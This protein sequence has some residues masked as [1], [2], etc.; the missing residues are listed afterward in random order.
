M[1]RPYGKREFALTLARRSLS[2]YADDGCPQLAASIAYHVLFSLFPLAI[3]L[4]AGTSVVLNATGSRRTV[5]DTI[6]RNVPLSQSG[7]DQL[8][9]LLLGATGQLSA[10]GFVG[11]LG[12]LY[13][14][15]G[16]M[17]ALRTALSR[18]WDLEEA[19]PYLR[20]KLVDLGLVLLVALL[21][22]A[23]LGLTIALRF[24]GGGGSWTTSLV[25]PLV[26]A[27]A[28]VLF[29][30]RVV[31]DT[32]VPFREAWAPAAFVAFAFTA[33]ENLF[34]FYVGHFGD[35]NAVYGSLGAVI[36]FIYFVYLSSE[37]FLLGAEAASEWPHVRRALEQGLPD[38]PA[39]Q[40]T[41]RLRSMLVGL[42]R[43]PSPPREDSSAG[44]P[45]TGKGTR[46]EER[47][48]LELTERAASVIK[49]IL[50]ES[51]AGAEGG[52]R[53]SGNADAAGS[54]KLEFALASSPLEG[55]EVVETQGAT[56]FLD[57]VAALVLS[58]KKLD[59]ET[60]DDHVHFALGER[61]DEV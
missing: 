38:E 11:I 28:V 52:L 24:V 3:V 44:I 36:A 16:M 27:F 40:L 48:M 8:R 33:A 60:H 41:D 13:S 43:R 54:A 1:R 23:S 35:Y 17:A 61:E 10:L 25:A 46:R 47:A 5:V 22:F 50:D 4:T 2:E 14:A 42:W 12:L 7:D 20:G 57:E 6:V 39:V 26:L 59:A 53:I 30:Y 34:A 31:P 32:H 29:L 55:D 45:D 58:D 37:L 56:V 21:G 51:P 19:R 18:A 49:D 9:T 15:S